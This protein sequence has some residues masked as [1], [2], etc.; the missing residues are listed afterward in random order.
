M[1]HGIQNA[2]VGVRQ[3][4]NAVRCRLK[5]TFMALLAIAYYADEGKY[6]FQALNFGEHHV[7]GK[8]VRQPRDDG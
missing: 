8:T 1:N 6:A 3:G 7:A 2:E 4:R 5:P